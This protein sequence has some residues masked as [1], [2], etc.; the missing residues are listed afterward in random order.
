MNPNDNGDK[1]FRPLPRQK[2][3][4]TD[5]YLPLDTTKIVYTILKYRSTV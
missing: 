4:E 3:N 2:K 5:S 1:H